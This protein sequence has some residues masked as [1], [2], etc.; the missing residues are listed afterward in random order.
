MAVRVNRDLTIP[1]DEIKLR[2]STSGGPGGQHANRSAT[3]VELV[4]NV[5][6]SRVLSEHRRRQIRGRLRA[7]IDSSGEL[8]LA[9]DEHRSQLRNRNEVER[10]LAALVADALEPRPR[11][12][13]TAPSRAAR[14]RRLDAKR[15]RSET[16]RRRRPPAGD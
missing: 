13:P 14:T 3:R 7:R 12:V 6:R 16:K 4:W 8:R 11:R 10:R 5:D 15:R 2:F 9:S 1:D